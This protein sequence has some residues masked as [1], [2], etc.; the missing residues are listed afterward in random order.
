MSIKRSYDRTHCQ[1][2]SN[3]SFWNN[4]KNLKAT[5]FSF[6]ATS[7]FL[8]QEIMMSLEILMSLFLSCCLDYLLLNMFD[9]YYECTLSNHGNSLHTKNTLHISA[10][11]DLL[12]Q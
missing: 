5:G 12:G 1:T 6:V 9:A 2:F 8:S 7:L 10:F 11:S 3:S 4:N